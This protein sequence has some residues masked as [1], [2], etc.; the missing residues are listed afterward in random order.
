V[1]SFYQLSTRKFLARL[2]SFVTI[3]AKLMSRKVS[4]SWREQRVSELLCQET[5]SPVAELLKQCRFLLYLA[6]LYPKPF[7]NRNYLGTLLLTRSE[8]K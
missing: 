4:R 7:S 3:F 1:Y 5:A 2:F 8:R 6:E